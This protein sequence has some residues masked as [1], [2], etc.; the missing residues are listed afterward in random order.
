MR[1]LHIVAIEVDHLIVSLN[2][3][4]NLRI[5]LRFFMH[6]LIFL[7]I[8]FLAHDK[9]MNRGEISKLFPIMQEHFGHSM[10]LARIKLM[11]L[12]LE[13]LFKAQTV[14]LVRLANAMPT[15]VDKESNM[16]RLQR[17]LACYVL[18]LGLLEKIIKQ[19]GAIIRDGTIFLRAEQTLLKPGDTLGL[20]EN[21]FMTLVN[22]VRK[23]YCLVIFHDI[24]LLNFARTTKLF[25][26]IYRYLAIV[27]TCP[28][29]RRAT[30]K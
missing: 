23:H 4:A 15:A 26:L 9:K 8:K 6:I 24:K 29:H 30:H 10:N 5:F 13:A 19:C 28:T 21:H 2:V 11:S 16:R 25:Y 7:K 14:S 18:N 1:T 20:T 12:L 27:C 17:F 3:S 22:L